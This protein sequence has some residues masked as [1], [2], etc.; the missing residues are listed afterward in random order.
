MRGREFIMKDLY[1]FDE[2][3]EGA[4]ATYDDVCGAYERIFQRIGLPFVK[5]DAD[6]GSIGGSLSHE[7]QLVSTVGEDSILQCPCG[8]YAANTERAQAIAAP[9]DPATTTSAFQ[10][11]HEHVRSLLGKSNVHLTEHIRVQVKR[12]RNKIER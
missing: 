9:Y 3:K 4:M 2:T 7:F 8:K 1:T 10:T 6:T 11:Q 12:R 5:V